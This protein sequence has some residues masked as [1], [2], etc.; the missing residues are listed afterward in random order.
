MINFFTESPFV[1]DMNNMNLPL[2][3]KEFSR[4]LCVSKHSINIWNV[5]FFLDLLVWLWEV[6]SFFFIFSSL[7]YLFVI[8]LFYKHVLTPCFFRTWKNITC[9]RDIELLSKS[10][11]MFSLCNKN[12]TLSVWVYSH[13]MI[14]LLVK[15]SPG[16]STLLFKIHCFILFSLSN[17]YFY[18]SL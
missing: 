7:V 10:N 6:F 1:N 12:L 3:K 15:M 9:K 13:G 11:T 4:W 2:D 14:L 5:D 17:Y 18:H 16:P 8:R